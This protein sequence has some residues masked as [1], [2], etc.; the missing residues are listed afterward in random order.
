MVTSG[1]VK[2]LEALKVVVGT[3]KGD[4]VDKRDALNGEV[5]D[6]TVE[7]DVDTNETRAVDGMTV[8]I[9]TSMDAGVN[10]TVDADT[11]LDIDITVDVDTFVDIDTTVDVDTIIGVD[12]DA[13]ESGEVDV[14]TLDVGT[15][16]GES[17]VD[18]I[19]VEFDT[20]GNESREVRVV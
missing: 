9:D 16:T 13:N 6:I 3:A 4:A 7:V 14:I 1:L 19:T 12:T 8:D 20:G 10:A 11:T 5:D 15:D 18:D 2:G 17:R